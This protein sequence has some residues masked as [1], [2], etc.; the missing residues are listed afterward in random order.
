MSNT[1]TIVGNLTRDPELRFTQDGTPVVSCDVAINDRR[2]NKSTGEYEDAG[3]TYWRCTAFRQTAENISN[4]LHKGDQVIV[5]G[6]VKDRSFQ[7]KEGEN[8]TV[9]EIDISA[10]GPSLRFA[11]ATVSKGSPAGRQAPAAAPAPAAPAAE[12]PAMDT[13]WPEPAAAG[14][15]PF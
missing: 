3:T 8:R 1:I 4:S 11:T 6:S 10:I 9:K 13:S 12:S 15:P 5:S 7:T 2:F 14:A